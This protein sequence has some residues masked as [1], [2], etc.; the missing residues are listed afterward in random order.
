MEKMKDS[1]CIRP[2]PMLPI[3]ITLKEHIMSFAPSHLITRKIAALLV[4]F[5]LV[6][7]G[8]G[9][10]APQPDNARNLNE[11][12]K[13]VAASPIRT[14][15]DRSSDEKRKPVEFLQFTKVRPGMLVLDIAAGGGYT[16][17][18]LALAVGGNGT[19]WAQSDTQR[20]AL[21]KRLA[22]HPQPNIVALVQSFQDPVPNEAPKL[23]LITIIMNYHDIAY[24][25]IDRAGMNQRLFNALK[26]GGHLVV[27]DHS[28]KA[29]TGISAAKTLHRI[30]EAIVLNEFRQAGFKLEQEGDFMRNPT[31]PRDRAF[32]DMNAP[33]DKFALRFVK[34]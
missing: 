14:D 32:F 2:V 13:Q 7:A 31:D 26:P 28:A 34:P 12:Y 17:Q 9:N 11:L 4:A 27:M 18:L 5:G 22:A 10:A 24:M 3:C 1:Q 29:G 23:D 19:V 30:D 6:W 16:T 15:E 25:P 20:P 33:T 21:A 8:N